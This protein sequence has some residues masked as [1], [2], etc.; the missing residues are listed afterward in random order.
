MVE[1]GFRAGDPGTKPLL[2]KVSPGSRTSG[3]GQAAVTWK[4]LGWPLFSN[5]AGMCP[6]KSTDQKTG[7]TGRTAIGQPGCWLAR[8]CFP[9]KSYCFEKFGQT[10]AESDIHRHLMQT[11]TRKGFKEPWSFD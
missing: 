7:G 2:G 11:L 3:L 8:A 10:P 6:L 4:S 5:R 1:V 9:R